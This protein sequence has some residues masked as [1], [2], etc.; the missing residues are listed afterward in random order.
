ISQSTLLAYFE[1]SCPSSV[2]MQLDDPPVL[3]SLFTVH[4]FFAFFISGGLPPQ[5]LCLLFTG[6]FLLQHNGLD[7]LVVFFVVHIRSLDREPGQFFDALLAL[8]DTELLQR[9]IFQSDK[10]AE[11]ILLQRTHDKISSS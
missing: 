8:L 7:Q 1:L 2:L 4:V 5:N 6:L 11:D 10:V 3:N 9:R